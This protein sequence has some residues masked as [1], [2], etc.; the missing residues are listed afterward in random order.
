MDRS[1]ET[2]QW[3]FSRIHFKR[4][5]ASIDNVKWLTSA[6]K[7]GSIVVSFCAAEMGRTK[8]SQLNAQRKLLNKQRAVDVYEEHLQVVDFV[9]VF[10]LR[11]QKP[12]CKRENDQIREY[13]YQ[14]NAAGAI[15]NTFYRKTLFSYI[16]L[17]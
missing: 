12:V 14:I 9:M 4:G 15:R 16:L 13:I 1:E 6:V 17:F 10:M 3:T 8:S 7:F 11:V 2:R 5:K